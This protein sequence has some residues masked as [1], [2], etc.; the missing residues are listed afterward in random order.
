[1]QNNTTNE[2]E[3]TVSSQSLLDKLDFHTEEKNV[4]VT[5][6]ANP[7]ANPTN[8]NNGAGSFW[9]ESDDMD[10]PPAP[11]I[12]PKA[13]TELP[14]TDKKLTDAVFKN[15]ASVVTGS[16]EFVSSGIIMVILKKRFKSQF[17]EKEYDEYLLISD[18]KDADLT[19]PQ[20]N[21]KNRIDLAI[22][23]F[24]SLKAKV[25]FTDDEEKDLEAAW[26]GYLKTKNIEVPPSMLVA[27]A[28]VSIVGKRVLDVALD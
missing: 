14:T 26:Y 17:T 22:K 15:G 10:A 8:T 7:I 4:T 11:P 27:L 23:K 9:S 2:V 19:E 16:L 13:E 25:P 20:L 3:E 28:T 12:E 5:A 6:V 21:L 1:M 24:E 18:K